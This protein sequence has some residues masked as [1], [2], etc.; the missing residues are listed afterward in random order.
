MACIARGLFDGS[1]AGE[2]DQVGERDPLVAF[3][4]IVEA[5]PDR[6]QRLQD[7]GQ[8]G[9]LI[10]LPVLLRSEANPRAVRA[11]ALVG[12]AEG[13]C[14]RPGRG[15][16]LRH[17]QSRRQ[18]RVLER[19]DI[20]LVDQ[21][22]GDGRHRVLP[23]ERFFGHFRA[24]V[25]RAG[26]HVAVGELEP[27]AR[28]GIG[29]FVRMRQEAPGDRFIGRVEPQREIG[30]QHGRDMPPAGIEC[31]R[32]GGGAVLRLPLVRACR[33]L[34]QF[35]FVAKEVLEEVVAPLRRRGRPGDLQAAGDGVAALAGAKTAG[36]AEP[37]LFEAAGF[38]FVGDVRGIA[39][40][41]GLAEAVAAGDQC[42]GFFVIHRHARERVAD[43]MCGGD[44]IGV[45]VGA[46]GVH[47]DQAHLHGCQRIFQ[48]ARVLVA[49][50]VVVGDHDA[51]GLCDA[52][53]TTRIALVTTQPG[54]LLAPI[55]VLV[56][57]PGVLA[58]T[59]E[60]ERLEAHGFERDVACQDH[61]VRPRNLAAILLLDRPDQAARLVQRHVVRPT[62]Q[63]G[64]A[65]LATAAAAASIADAV[66]ASA[67]PGHA[68]EQWPVVAEVG[69]PPVLRVGHQCSEVA[70]HRCK[71]QRLELASRSR[72]P[73]PSGSNARNA[74]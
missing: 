32:N 49:I 53:G 72:N 69:R 46:L 27:R 31:I 1:V 62:V 51:A 65:L 66:G 52:L 15:H 54:G 68:D 37:L 35:P 70:L 3:L 28:E 67:V 47:V 33:A 4:C 9:G 42:D 60:A 56:R 16:Q 34:G 10:D 41:V 5:G 40:T 74:G 17:G 23:D 50:G 21:C 55:D 36:P 11:A 2:H 19:R 61:Q 20:G 25:A 8:P 26:T 71:V 7:L 12:T 64:E 39:G 59:G 14:R 6:F 63:R 13:G 43:V 48:V 29:E 57:F 45:A 44:R 30:R 18:D 22:M 73:R 58:A 38:G 24:E